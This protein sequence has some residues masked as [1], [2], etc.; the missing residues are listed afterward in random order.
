MDSFDPLKRQASKR[1]TY[2]IAVSGGSRLIKGND[3]VAKAVS[4]LRDKGLPCIL[5]V[6][7]DIGFDEPRIGESSIPDGLIFKGQISHEAFL[8]DLTSVDL[9]IMNS[10]HD[11]FGMSALDALGAGLQRSDFIKLW[12]ER[13]NRSKS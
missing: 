4:R 10:R 11:S 5:V 8:N 2:V 12:S 1:E 7:G 6:Y 13:S 3:I 9:F